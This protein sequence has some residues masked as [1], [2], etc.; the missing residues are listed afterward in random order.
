VHF[1][2]FYGECG[3]STKVRAV[4]GFV[5]VKGLIKRTRHLLENKKITKENRMED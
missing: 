1:T 3:K 2:T 4:L 5:V